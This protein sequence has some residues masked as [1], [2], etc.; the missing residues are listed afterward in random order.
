[1]WKLKTILSST[2]TLLRMTVVLGKLDE[3][4]DQTQAL[5]LCVQEVQNC[6]EPTDEEF[7]EA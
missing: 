3:C 5:Q 2:K 4:F 6:K 1:M 7:D